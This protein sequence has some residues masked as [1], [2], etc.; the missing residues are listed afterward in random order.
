MYKMVAKTMIVGKELYVIPIVFI[1]T[2]HAYIMTMVMVMV[3]II[4][5]TLNITL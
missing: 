2:N 5:Y 4:S 3:K 1:F